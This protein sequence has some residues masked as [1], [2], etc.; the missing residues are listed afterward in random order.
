VITDDVAPSQEPAIK[1]LCDR[2]NSDDP[3]FD[4][5]SSAARWLRYLADREAKILSQLTASQAELLSLRAKHDKIMEA[6][7]EAG[8]DLIAGAQALAMQSRHRPVG[9][10]GQMKN[11]ARKLRALS[12]LGEV[13]G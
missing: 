6:L 9:R 7:R 10:Q 8:T 2:L 1:I 11:A 13:T 4:D 5:C 12:K 3:D